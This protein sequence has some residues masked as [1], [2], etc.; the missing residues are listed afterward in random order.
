MINPE[1]DSKLEGATP[2]VPTVSLKLNV[3]ELNI[4]LGGLQELPHR[5]VDTLIRNI[6]DQASTQ[7]KQ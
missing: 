5:A 6:M 7:L 3:N 1:L 4:V 2:E